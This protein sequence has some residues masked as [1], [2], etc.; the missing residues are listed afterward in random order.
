MCTRYIFHPENDPVVESII[1][2]ENGYLFLNDE[3][4][5]DFIYALKRDFG[6]DEFLSPPRISFNTAPTN[7]GLVIF[8]KGSRRIADN[9]HFGF[10]RKWQ[11]GSRAMYNPGTNFRF[12]NLL[13][14]TPGFIAKGLPVNDSKNG[15]WM[16]YRAFEKKQFCLI[17][18]RAFVEFD[19]ESREVQLKTKTTIKEFSVPYLTELRTKQLACVAGL[20]EYAEDEQQYR[21]TFGTT[22]P[23][24]LVRKFHH[25]RFPV[26]LLSKE[27]QNLWLDPDA[28]VEEKIRMG[29]APARSDLFQS[30]RVSEKINKAQNKGLEVIEKAEGSLIW[31]A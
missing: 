20:W 9:Y 13:P 8:Y 12:D 24:D 14:N 17:P 22:E 3:A 7:T 5:G 26:F 6:I 31:V 25:D 28:P 29:L 15:N 23:N 30:W 11:Q 4:T 2:D 18:L 19:K 16:Y 10:K 21:F 1:N 27:E